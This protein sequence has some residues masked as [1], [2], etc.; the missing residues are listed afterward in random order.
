MFS[1][2]YLQEPLVTRRKAR[3]FEENEVRPFSEFLTDSFGRQHTYLRISLTERC[4]LRCK[5]HKI[6]FTNALFMG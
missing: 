4:N 3:Y 6:Q 2:H 1:S 5:N